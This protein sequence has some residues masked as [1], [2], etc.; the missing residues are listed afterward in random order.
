MVVTSF[1]MP[2]LFK[3]QF[4]LRNCSLKQLASSIFNLGQNIGTYLI[5][6]SLTINLKLVIEENMTKQS[7]T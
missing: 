1:L 5:Y 6:Y 7:K 2:L 3:M 4:S